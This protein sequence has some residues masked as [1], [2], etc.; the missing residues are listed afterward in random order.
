MSPSAVST[1]YMA[2]WP[3]SRAGVDPSVGACRGGR[4]VEGCQ[5]LSER[6]PYG[7]QVLV[8]VQPA[9]S[10][11]RVIS[12]AASRVSIHVEPDTAVSCTRTS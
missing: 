1:P 3:H 9:G 6:G 11:V 4:R 10:Q 2:L 5:A 12:P 8:S 7:S